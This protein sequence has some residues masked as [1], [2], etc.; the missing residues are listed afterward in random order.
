[1]G[2]DLNRLEPP[3]IKDYS[4]RMATWFI[5]KEGVFL[6]YMQSMEGYDENCSL[7]FVNKWNDRRVTINEITF[8]V[9]EEVIAMATGLLSKGKKWRKVM[10]TLDEASMNNFFNE[11]EEPVR[12]RG[13]LGGRN[14]WNH[15]M[16]CVWCL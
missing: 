9:N 14:Y 12:L 1:M 13:A 16:M 8:Q 3:K 11:G 10:K 5:F 6:P 4:T 15:G 7:Q 2:G